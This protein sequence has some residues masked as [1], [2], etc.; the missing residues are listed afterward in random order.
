[1]IRL[2]V[3]VGSRRRGSENGDEIVTV[4]TPATVEYCLGG[5]SAFPH[6]LLAGIAQAATLGVS[7]PRET[8][9]HRI[10][11]GAANRMPVLLR[12]MS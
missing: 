1:M 2:P 12:M 9:M 8:R 4:V 5:G 3:Q 11:A 10:V 6:L 7:F